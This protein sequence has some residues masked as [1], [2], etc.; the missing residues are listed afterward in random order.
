MSSTNENR[1]VTKESF[2]SNLIRDFMEIMKDKEFNFSNIVPILI[3][4][5]ETAGYEKCYAELKKRM[6]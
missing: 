5:L 4:I 3:S 2:V 1:L 6:Y